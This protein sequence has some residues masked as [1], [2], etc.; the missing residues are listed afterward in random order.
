MTAPLTAL[1]ISLGIFFSLFSLFRFEK[2]RGKRLL[3]NVRE[4]LDFLILKT[5]HAFLKFFRGAGRSVVRQVAHYFFHTLLRALLAFIAR[6]EKF[7]K[8]LMR[9]NR[10]I[11][12]KSERERTERNK[13]EEIALHK[14][15]VALSDVEKRRH[16]E[17]SLN[18]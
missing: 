15:E 17:R 10:V 8:N 4:H 1:I 12:N 14:M 3:K 16:K 18:G 7:L 5:T 6:I 9:S 13:L 2:N 11:A